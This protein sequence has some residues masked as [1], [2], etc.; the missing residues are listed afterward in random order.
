MSNNN[1]GKKLYIRCQFIFGMTSSCA[2]VYRWHFDLVMF[3]LA[4]SSENLWK[5]RNTDKCHRLTEKH[6]FWKLW[7]LSFI[8]MCVRPST[9]PSVPVRRVFHICFFF[10]Y[11]L[12]IPFVMLSMMISTGVG[13]NSDPSFLFPGTLSTLPNSLLGS[14]TDTTLFPLGSRRW[15]T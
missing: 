3:P 9:R 2:F 6:T 4:L 10:L 13:V 8:S 1:D 7:M 12:W 14:V 15:V 5:P 11:K